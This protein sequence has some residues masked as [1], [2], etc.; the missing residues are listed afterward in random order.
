MKKITLAIAAIAC[1]TGCKKDYTCTCVDASPFDNVGYGGRVE[2]FEGL[3]KSEAKDLQ[4]E[5]CPE[6]DPFGFFTCTWTQE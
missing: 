6:I 3:S 2:T 4:I 1:V 5:E